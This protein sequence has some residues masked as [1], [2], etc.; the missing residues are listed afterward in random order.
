MFKNVVLGMHLYRNFTADTDIS[1]TNFAAKQTTH[2]HGATAFVRG[3]GSFFSFSV[4]CVMSTVR[5]GA[6]Y[7]GKAE[8]AG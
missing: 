4:P 6:I 3:W 1:I 5:T 8:A 7:R 2:A